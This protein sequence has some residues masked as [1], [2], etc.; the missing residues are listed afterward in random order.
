MYGVE[1]LSQ[2]KVLCEGTFSW[3]KGSVGVYS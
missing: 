2:V 3:H 1:F